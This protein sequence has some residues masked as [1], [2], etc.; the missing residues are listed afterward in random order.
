MYSIKPSTSE[1]ATRMTTSEDTSPLSSVAA[2]VLLHATVGVY[3]TVGAFD[4]ALEEWSEYTERLVHY[5][6]PNIIVADNKRQVIFLTIVGPTSYCL[7]KMLASPK[8][9]DEF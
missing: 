3:G 4:P 8:K 2:S 1:L 6:M 7:L 9:L 5:F